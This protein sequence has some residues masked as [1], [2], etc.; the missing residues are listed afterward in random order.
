MMI[1]KGGLGAGQWVAEGGVF[2]PNGRV[3]PPHPF[4]T[5]IKATPVTIVPCYHC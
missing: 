5:V 3:K 4:G 1:D 2:W